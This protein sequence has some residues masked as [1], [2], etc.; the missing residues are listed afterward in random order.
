MAGLNCSLL[1]GT[2]QQFGPIATMGG[3]FQA[4]LSNLAQNHGREC[5]IV[6]LSKM[7]RSSDCGELLISYDHVVPADASFS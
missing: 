3:W 7:R 2:E 5:V 4:E 6:N 1:P